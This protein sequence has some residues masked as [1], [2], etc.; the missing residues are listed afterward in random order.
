MAK[1]FLTKIGGTKRLRLFDDAIKEVRA[2]MDARIKP[3][4]IKSLEKVVADW[5]TDVG[6]AGRTVV[7][8]TE[9]A[10]YVFPTGEGKRIFVFVD[11]GTKPHKIRAKN[12]PALAF[13]MHTQGGKPVRGGYEP[14]TLANP[15]RT[16]VGGGYVKSPKTLVRP[17]EVDHPG[18]E[19][20]DFT[21]QIAR[22]LRPEFKRAMDAAF[23]R[24]ARKANRG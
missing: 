11:K 19:G 14:K 15:A 23:A 20:R 2:E 13:M 16:V 7:R 5:E 3:A 12:A 24:A 8:G 22:D 21:G 1:A 10:V 17:I 4:M 18:T 9:I 6:F